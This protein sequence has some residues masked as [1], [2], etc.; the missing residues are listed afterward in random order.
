M[1]TTG[2]KSSKRLV[3]RLTAILLVMLLLVSCGRNA[4]PNEGKPVDKGKTEATVKPND[5]KD[6]DKKDDNKD[7][8]SS[9]SIVAESYCAYMEAKGELTTII[10]DALSDNPG[11]ELDSLSLLGV[12]LVDLALFPA[13][14]FGLGEAAANSALGFLGV[15]DVDYKENGNQYSI[16]YTDDEGMKYEL[17]GVYD[18]SADSLKLTAITDGKETVV[19]EY[20]KSSFGYVA[21]T[22]VLDDDDSASIFYLAISG[23]NGAIGISEASSKPSDLTGS[24]SIDFPKT[25]EEWYAID[26]DDFTGVTSDGRELSFKYTPSDD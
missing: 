22:Y 11:T 23:K 13:T 9:Q 10:S 16:Q 3:F 17:Q 8:G 4:P 12:I 15:K 14:S 20:R 18:K 6:D 1:F 26:G 25:S 24:E 7:P 21:Q 5:H 19:S 2:N